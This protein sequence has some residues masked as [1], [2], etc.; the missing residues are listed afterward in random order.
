MARPNPRRPFTPDPG[1]PALRPQVS[2]NE[3]NG[4]NEPDRRRPSI[5]YWAPQ[6]DDIAHGAMQKWF[7]TVDPGLPVFAEMRAKRQEVSQ[8]A[9]PPIA[10][11]AAWHGPAEWVAL[12]DRF[13][14]EGHCEQIGVAQMQPQW[15]SRS[16]RGCGNRVGMPSP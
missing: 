3:I 14:E 1:Q 15:L 8:R 10:D 2:G 7:F 6:P 12:L 5:V 16:R 4:L 9:L 11:V 13:V